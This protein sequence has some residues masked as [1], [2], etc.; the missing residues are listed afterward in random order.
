M[1]ALFV[2]RWE[3]KPAPPRVE[4]SRWPWKVAP[5]GADAQGSRWEVEEPP[6]TVSLEEV[7]S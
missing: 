5:L 6:R 4:V 1:K 7:Q 3:A 2:E